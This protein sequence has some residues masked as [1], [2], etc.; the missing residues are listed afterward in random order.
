MRS[1]ALPWLRGVTSHR[2][3]AAAGHGSISEYTPKPSRRAWRWALS[4]SGESASSAARFRQQRLLE[5]DGHRRRIP[6]RTA[7]GL[8]QHF[9]DQP[10]AA[11]A[12]GGQFIASP[13]LPCDLHS[14]TEIEA[15]PSGEITE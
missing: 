15:Q 4:A 5:R 2:R 8:A 3:T 13:P 11:Q 12:L 6:V 9:I 10:Q 14:S 7:E 1:S